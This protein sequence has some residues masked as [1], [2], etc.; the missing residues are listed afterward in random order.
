MWKLFDK[1]KLNQPGIGAALA[2][3]IPQLIKMNAPIN[4]FIFFHDKISEK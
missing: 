2:K 1:I 3:T 4:E